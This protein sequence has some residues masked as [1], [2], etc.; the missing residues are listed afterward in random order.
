MDGLVS[1]A[2]QVFHPSDTVEISI[3]NEDNK[4]NMSIGLSFSRR[5]QISRYVFWSM[6]EKV[7]QSNAESQDLDTLTFHVNSVPISVEYGKRAE[8]P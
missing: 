3:N 4:Q 7:T 5:V 2:L 6:L 1:Y 8:T